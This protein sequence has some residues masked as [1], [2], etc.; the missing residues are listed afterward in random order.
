MNDNSLLYK[1]V[2]YC[3]GRLLS[4][5]EMEAYIKVY[6]S[7]KSDTV[8]QHGKKAIIK[9][10]KTGPHGLLL[11]G[12]GDWNDGMNNVGAKGIG[13]TVWG[14]FFAVYVMERFSNVATSVGD[15]KFAQYCTDTANALRVNIEASAWD[16]QWYRRG[17]FDNGDPLGSYVSTE[18]QIDILP[19][20]F[21]SICGGFDPSRVRSGLDSVDRLLVDRECKLVKLFNPPFA[22]SKNNPG[23]IMSYVSGV[24]E[25]GGQYTH[26]AIWYALA[27]IKDCQFERGY[28]ILSLINPV[29]RTA[30]IDEVKKYRVE[31][32]VLAGDVY[33]SPGHEGMGGWTHYTGAAG[34]YFRVIIEEVLGIKI[35]GN[36]I[37]ISPSLPKDW[38]EFRIDLFIDSAKIKILVRKARERKITV[39]RIEVDKIILDGND[40]EIV[41]QY[42]PV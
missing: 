27:L 39:D 1:D 16:G 12:G 21:A 17:Y 7:E 6:A 8:Y 5:E 29:N 37:F 31:P 30:S 33:S 3:E 20:S 13:E 35:R 18:G 2:S 22:K 19:Q 42:L 15:E 41:Y 14:S 4:D 32:Y 28:E 36:R 23:Y 10:I 26:A 34:W 9:A 11:F 25:N 24:R 40:H 38:R